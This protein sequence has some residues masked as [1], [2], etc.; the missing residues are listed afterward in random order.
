LHPIRVGARDCCVGIEYGLL[1]MQ[2]GGTQRIKAPP[3]LTHVERKSLP[4]L[5]ENAILVYALTLVEIAGK[6]DA[7]SFEK[8]TAK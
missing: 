1:G 2:S 7:N 5:S 4:D 3:H 8:R 6:W